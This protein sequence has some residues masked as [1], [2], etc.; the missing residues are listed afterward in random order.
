MPPD[1]HWQESS[2]RRGGKTA[3][4]NGIVATKILV[5]SVHWSQIKFAET[6][7]GANRKMDLTLKPAEGRTQQVPASRS[8]SPLHWESR[9]S[10]SRGSQ[11]GFGIQDKRRR[12][13]EFS[14]FAL[15]GNS[16]QATV[17]QLGIWVWQLVPVVGF[18]V[19]WGFPGDFL[20]VIQKGES[21]PLQ[22]GFQRECTIKLS[23]KM[24][25]KQSKERYQTTRGG[26]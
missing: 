26:L 9:G 24:R 20:L 6:E 8:L 10:N 14:L 7:F 5:F 18:I 15:F 16:H 2:W 12:G 13:P 17:R 4:L 11:S 19:L 25:L 23:I 3:R 22:G 1:P 21:K